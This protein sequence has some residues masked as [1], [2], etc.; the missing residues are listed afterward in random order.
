MRNACDTAPL[1]TGTTLDYF[2]SVGYL[3]RPIEIL[4]S[5]ERTGAM[6][7]FEH[8][9]NFVGEECKLCDLLLGRA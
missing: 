2:N 8:F 4:N 6:M 1:K 7:S 9:S 5:S 3:P